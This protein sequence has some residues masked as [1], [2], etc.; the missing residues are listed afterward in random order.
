M[1][2]LLVPMSPE[3]FNEETNEF[4][5]PETY[6]LGLE[7]SLVSVSKWESFFEKPFLSETPK[8]E[9]ETLWYISAMIVDKNPPGEILQR[10]SKANFD[11][12]VEYIQAK[13]TATWVNAVGKGRSREVITAEVIYYWMIALQIPIEAQYWHLNKLL[14]LIKVTNEKNNPKKMSKQEAA[15]KQREL[16]NARRAQYGTRG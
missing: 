1:L 12:I 8:T 4:V 10:F 5:P 13:N 2:T 9:E 16:N 11:S 7:H 15:R 3:G 6:A 14:T